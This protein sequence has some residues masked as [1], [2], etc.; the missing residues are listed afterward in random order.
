MARKRAG[1]SLAVVFVGAAAFGTSPLSIHALVAHASPAV[2]ETDD[3]YKPANTTIIGRSNAVS[4][5]IP[6]T[7]PVITWTCTNSVVV[8]KTPATGL[9]TYKITPPTFNDGAGKPCIDNRGFSDTVVSHGTWYAGFVDSPL[10]EL[11]KEPNLGDRLKFII[12]IGGV[13]V[14]TSDG[15][16]L[17]FAPTA[18][19]KAIGAYNDIN[20]FSII[21]VVP[22][23]IT[24][25]PQC[26]VS[27]VAAA[28][29]VTYTLTP[30][31][32]DAS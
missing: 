28:F 11:S 20:K 4:I 8:Q 29:S 24:G 22:I 7:T 5:A 2:T 30:G 15:C 3:H 10:D 17:T 14:T 9:G 26:P 13:T 12:P 23:K 18:P 27:S 16:L 1:L 21:G 32:S 25:G 19:L 31:L 6:P